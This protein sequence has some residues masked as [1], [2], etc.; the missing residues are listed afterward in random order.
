VR[1]LYLAVPATEYV[2]G[3][4]S[5]RPGTGPAADRFRITEACDCFPVQA[6][7]RMMILEPIVRVVS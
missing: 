7:F 2:S 6:F 4:S 1:S 3:R 5:I